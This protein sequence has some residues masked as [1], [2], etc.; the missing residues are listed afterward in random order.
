MRLCILNFGEKFAEEDI[1]EMVNSY[2]ENKDGFL[3]F[4][5]FVNM[6]SSKMNY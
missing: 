5:E 6:L 2:D 1:E 3:E 4:D